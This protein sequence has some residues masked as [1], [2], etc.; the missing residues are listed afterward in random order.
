MTVDGDAGW[1][2]RA[3]ALAEGGRGT[4]SPNPMV[5]AVLVRDGRIVGEGFHRAAGAPHAETAALAAAGPL[6][7]G[8]TCYVTLEPCVHHGRTPPCVDALLQAG[9]VRVVAA[10]VDPDR[11]VDGAGLARLRAAGAM[12]TVG[13]GAEAAAEQNAAYLTHRRLGRP[14][15]TLKAAASLDG[16]VAAPDG[17]SQWITGPAA[18]ADAHRLRAEADAV[19][20]GAGTARTDD[21]RLTARLH[22]P[23]GAPPWGSPDPNDRSTGAPPWGSPDPSGHVDRQPLRVLVDAAGQVGAGGHLFDAAAPT[24]VATT[25]AAH[26]TAVDAWKRA[27]AEVLVCPEAAWGNGRRGVDLSALVAAL[28]RRGVL[29]LLVEGGPRLH[30][31]F[32]AAG[33]ADRL[34]WYLAPLVI[35]GDG[36]PGLLRG[37]GA[38]TLAAARPVRIASVERLGADVRVVAYPRPTGGAESAPPDPPGPPGTPEPP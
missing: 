5:G 14:R 1:M 37:G 30:A 10:V 38:P 8:A 2:A 28:G 7:A 18:R 9:V 11:R 33:L 24:M 6:A 4:A 3:V 25:A 26:A 32:W 17:S 16:K 27:G 36:A 31:S 22:R 34:V 15:V 35:G 13:V 21:P 23:T 12:V 19:A 29:E 20:V